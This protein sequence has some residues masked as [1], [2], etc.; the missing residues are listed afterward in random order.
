MTFYATLN[1]ADKSGDVFKF[2]LNESGDG[3]CILGHLSMLLDIKLSNKFVLTCDRDEKIRV[4]HYPNAYN[5]HNYCLGHTDFI[6]SMEL[7]NDTKL[8]SGSGDGTLKT[9]EFLKVAFINHFGWSNIGQK[10]VKKL[11]TN[12]SK[13]GPKLVKSWSEMVRNSQ[14]RSKKIQGSSQKCLEYQ[15]ISLKLV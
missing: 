4:S 8:I 2:D 13:M 9:W 7:L 6:T 14:K 1:F 10:W 15:K 3:N 5:I 11:V 12:G